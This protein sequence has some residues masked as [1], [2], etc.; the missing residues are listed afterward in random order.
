MAY[1]KHLEVCLLTLDDE[2]AFDS[3]NPIFL[4]WF[5]KKYGNSEKF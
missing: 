5:L 4:F 3:L 2:K 1:S